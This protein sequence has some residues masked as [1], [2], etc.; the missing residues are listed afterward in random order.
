MEEN[1][2]KISEPTNLT[3]VYHK[4]V[5]DNLV[6]KV[7][8]GEISALEMYVS[9]KNIEKIAEGAKKHKEVA[10]QA[11]EE[12]HNHLE[13]NKKSFDY[14]NSKVTVTSTYTWYDFNETGDIYYERLKELETQLKQ[15][16]K[17]REEYLKSLIP[18]P[19]ALKISKETVIVEQLPYFEFA[20]CGEEI[21]ISPPV[22][23]QKTGLKISFKKP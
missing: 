6:S 5:V 22:K 10:E 9:M 12:A 11:L 8:S 4:D 18:D 2:L 15:E 23:K 13:G 19:K 14:K 21:N 3:T 1:K 20:D 7:K 17:K 16:I